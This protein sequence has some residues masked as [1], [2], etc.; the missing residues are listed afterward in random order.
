MKSSAART[1]PA[2]AHV[3]TP[4]MSTQTIPTLTIG[5]L[6]DRFGMATHVLRHWET[7]G[8]LT[9]ARDGNGRR[10][11]GADD[12]VRVTVVLRA[13]AAGLSLE[14]IREMLAPDSPRARRDRLERHRDA[15]LLR[16]AEARASLDLI[17][18]ALGCDHDDFTTC[19]HFREL[20]AD[21]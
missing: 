1:V 4:R 18:C 15:L 3:S 21:M 11:Y 8:L 6:A 7:V 12:V 19:P 14:A 16:I 2:T 17:E 10:R 13:K 5:E 20:I 9:P